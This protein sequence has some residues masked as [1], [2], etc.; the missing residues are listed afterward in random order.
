ME[1]HIDIYLIRFHS[2]YMY[3]NKYIFVM[4]YCIWGAIDVE[5]SFAFRFY[6]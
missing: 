1:L 6:F 2:V 3:M 4:I 5:L